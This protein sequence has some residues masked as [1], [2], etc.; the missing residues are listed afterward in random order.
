ME[1]TINELRQMKHK[2]GMILQGCGGDI[3]EWV[4]GINELLTRRY[5]TGRDKVWRCEVIFP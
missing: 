4:N 3:Q 5:L 2:E 1:I